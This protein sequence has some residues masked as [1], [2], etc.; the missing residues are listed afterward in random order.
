MRLVIDKAEIPDANSLL[1]FSPPSDTFE[2]KDSRVLTA[3]ATCASDGKRLDVRLTATVMRLTQCRKN[4]YTLFLQATDAA[5][6][7]MSRLD[8]SVVS[9]VKSNVK[10][11]FEHSMNRDLVDEYYRRSSEVHGGKDITCRFVLASDTPPPDMLEVGSAA[12]ITL[13]LIGLQFRQ[14]YFTCLWK[15]VGVREGPQGCRIQKQPQF[16]FLNDDHHHH[17]HDHHDDDDGYIGPSAEDRATIRSAI[18]DKLVEMEK[19]QQTRLDDVR[20][21]LSTIDRCSEL[22]VIADLMDRLEN[23]HT[24]G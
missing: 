24:F 21:M 13:Q 8:D 1:T 11:W 15:I 5:T 12:R 6:L 7:F 17:H 18:V 20:D 23:V 10:S 3:T 14:Q 4:T 19:E 9:T 22:D 2:P 16:M